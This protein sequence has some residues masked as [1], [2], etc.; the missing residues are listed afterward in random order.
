MDY[1]TKFDLTVYNSQT[2]ALQ[3]SGALI[4]AVFW[5]LYLIS[6]T[7]YIVYVYTYTCTS[8]QPIARLYTLSCVYIHAQAV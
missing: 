5:V 6:H 7:P 3:F 4:A 2:D 1:Y 8:V